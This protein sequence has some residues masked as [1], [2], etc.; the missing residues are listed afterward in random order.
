LADAQIWLLPAGVQWQKGKS[1]MN[2]PIPDFE[3]E[4][5][6][7]P[8]LVLAALVLL[9]GGLYFAAEMPAY[10]WQTVDRAISLFLLLSAMSAIGWVLYNWKPLL[11]R[12]FAVLALVA[13]VHAGGWWLRIP[14]ALAWGVIPTALAAPLISFPAAVIAALAETTVVLGLYY[15]PAM[16]AGL[17]DATVALVAI[18]GVLGALF[19][20]RHRVRRQSAWYVEYFVHA[21]R[22]LWDAQNRR[23][24][25]RQ[26]LDDLMHANRQLTLMNERVTALRAVAEEARKAKTVFVAKVSHEFRTPLNMIV[27]LVDLMVET[28]EIYDVTLSPRMRQAL[29]V[30][31]RN[32]QHLSEMVND[33]LDLTR[34]E[35][36]RIVLHRERVN[37]REVID[38]AAE[39]VR[40]LLESKR[41]HFS[42]S[43]DDGTPEVYC[44]RTRIEQV[45]LNL[46]SNAARYTEE[47]SITVQVAPQDHRIRVS[48]TDTGPGIP[49][50]DLERIFEPFCQGTSDLW[51]HKGGSGLGLSISKQFIELHGGRMWVDSELG[52]GTA[53]TF[54]LP[55]SP[56]IAPIAR[57]GHQ[58]REDWIWRERRSRPSFPES[59]YDPRFVIYDETG[60]LPTS[61]APY[62]D[63]VEL[64]HS[65]DCVQLSQALQESPAH[66]IVFN[67]AALEDASSIIET[68]AEE[69]PG[70]PIIGCSVPVRVERA[71]ALGALGHLVKPVSRADLKQALQAIGRPVRRVLVVDDDPDALDLFREML[72]VCDSTLVVVTACSGQEALAQ[73]RRAPPDC[74]LLDIVMPDFDGWQVLAS[75]SQDSEIPDVP[76]FVISAQDPADQPLRS[77]FFLTTMDEGLSLGKLVRCALAVSR[78]LQQPE[79]ALDPVP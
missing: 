54:E 28:P 67:T 14:G 40:P 70:T 73:L 46:V 26:A 20:V 6:M 27:G 41:L 8:R 25:L 45:V 5:R 51:R 65:R 48:V 23:A 10:P 71:V 77:R 35:A 74:M 7:S 43:P 68:I 17:P 1:P 53:F 55:T 24:D 59:H 57:P 33:V 60:S 38:S 4:L 21:R 34:I 39:A 31:H 32:S 18:W 12:W 69:A 61:L 63:G 37:L 75:M 42:V 13:T 76:T 62:S 52:V 16:G 49:K 29:Q 22:S 78:L 30:V 72:R 9:G 50:R 66:A 15:S 47:G 36:D 44:D 2:D 79:G 64:V 19:A 58:I 56:D 3:S 11:G